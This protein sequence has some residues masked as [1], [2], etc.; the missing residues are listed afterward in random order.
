[1]RSGMSTDTAIGGGIGGFRFSIE[2]YIEL[3]RA[4]VQRVSR[5]SVSVDG[6]VVGAIEQGLLA[7]ICVA[8]GDGVP[9]A[10][11]MA[12]KLA[13]L[14]I[15]TD[16]QGRMNESVVDVGGGVLVVSQF[17]LCADLRKG[18][19]PSFTRAADSDH[20]EGV[21]EEIVAEIEK[22]GLVVA[23]GVFGAKMSVSIENDGPVTVVVDVEDGRVVERAG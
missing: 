9:E 4:V 20:A 11:A 22:R 21:I 6:E 2:G 17:T 3:V 12:S 8:H 15:F 16:D 14:R 19:R 1:M 5:S 7:L 10:T 23:T 18:N 13:Q